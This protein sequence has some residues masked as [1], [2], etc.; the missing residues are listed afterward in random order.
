MNIGIITFEYNFNYGTILQATALSD[1][2]RLKG[3]TV[4]IID[5][6]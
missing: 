6:G 3:H 4:K 2:L 1:Y 5:R